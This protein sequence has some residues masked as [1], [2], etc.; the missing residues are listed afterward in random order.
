MVQSALDAL[1]AGRIDYAGAVA[2]LT[3]P[4]WRQLDPEPASM[5]AYVRAEALRAVDRRRM[6]CDVV[7]EA[8]ADRDIPSECR[9]HLNR[10][11]VRLLLEEG[12]F[13]AAGEAVEV[14]RADAE[15]TSH[16]ARAL[17]DIVDGEVLVAQGML[18][19]AVE[20]LRPAVALLDEVDESGEAALGLER[21]SFALSVLGNRAEAVADAT[22]AVD[23]REHHGIDR[24][25][26]ISRANLGSIHRDGSDFDQAERQYA[27]ALST[28][29]LIDD[30]YWVG[31]VL[32][33]RG[34]C[35]LLEYEENRYGSAGEARSD[36]LGGAYADLSRSVD[37]CRWYNKLEL[38]KAIHE[39]G[40][41]LWERG[42]LI[43]TRSQWHEGLD[44]ARQSANFRYILENQIGLCELDIEAGDYESAL[45]HR[46]AIEDLHEL[47][48]QSHALLWKRLDKLEGEAFMA[49]G[50]HERAVG[51]F[52][53]AVP[54]LAAHGGWGR[55]RLDIELSR[56]RELIDRRLTGPDHSRVIEYL[57]NQWGHVARSLASPQDEAFRAAIE[58]FDVPTTDERNR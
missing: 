21:L 12:D 30:R 22:R 15:E 37:V 28:L 6:A 7:R 32:L 48:T 33:E 11:L 38:P 10:L 17:I 47:T 8:L 13:I 4:L 26:A 2:E 39:L 31:S 3:T 24:D 51:R 49:L 5:M 40:H 36:L 58:L 43:E 50:E 54:G 46:Q 20:A 1:K 16:V 18:R 14:A 41:V 35:R 52:A 44:L 57:V 45:T 34:L 9:L 23:L 25:T 19:E 55:Y 27:I 56:L 42:S 29:E 53:S